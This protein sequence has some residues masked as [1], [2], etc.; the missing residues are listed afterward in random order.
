M[1]VSRSLP[2]TSRVGVACAFG[3]LLLLVLSVGLPTARAD[4]Y[5]DIQKQQ[6][7]V[8][9]GIL[10][11]M[12][13]DPLPPKKEFE[14]VYGLVAKANERDRERH[15]ALVESLVAKAREAQPKSET[16]AQEY[17]KVAKVYKVIA[18]L[19]DQIVKGYDAADQSKMDQA[20]EGLTKAYAQAE[21]ILGKPIGRDWFTPSETEE[22]A[23]TEVA[24]RRKAAQQQQTPGRR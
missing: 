22:C 2:W 12:Q 6:I 15:R 5:T 18:D 8:H 1:R 13:K 4:S 21:K 16:K 24:G 19:N 11:R 3:G 23:F 14:L 9:M 17:L 20:I 10:A 7:Q